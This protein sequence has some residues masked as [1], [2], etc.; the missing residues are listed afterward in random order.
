[1]II[2]PAAFNLVTGPATGSCSSAAGRWT[3]RYLPAPAR[4][5]RA[6]G[7]L[8]VIASTAELGSQPTSIPAE[9]SPGVPITVPLINDL[10]LIPFEIFQEII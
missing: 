6:A 7:E 5:E 1:M 3:T 10:Y 2:V 9:A 8:E 4:D